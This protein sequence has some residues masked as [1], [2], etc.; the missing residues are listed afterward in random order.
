MVSTQK[1]KKPEKIKTA[2][3][4]RCLEPQAIRIFITFDFSNDEK[5]KNSANVMEKYY[6]PKE[7]FF[8][9]DINLIQE[10]KTRRK[11]IC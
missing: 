7:F 1:S 6:M 9:N 2:I 8:M 11:M 5:K 3:L 4:L 10:L